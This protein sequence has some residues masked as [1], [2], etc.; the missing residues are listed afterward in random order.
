M[1]KNC[2]TMFSPLLDKK[3]SEHLAWLVSNENVKCVTLVDN[4]LINGVY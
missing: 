1:C 3:A 4:V 2:G